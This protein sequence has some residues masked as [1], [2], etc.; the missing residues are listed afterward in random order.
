MEKQT[1]MKHQVVDKFLKSKSAYTKFYLSRRHLYARL[2]VL[3]NNINEIWCM[4]VVCMEKIALPNDGTKFLL[5]CV[6]V[7][8]RFI[9]V[10]TMK[11]NSAQQAKEALARMIL[12]S[13]NPPKRVW[14]DQGKEFEGTFKPFRTAMKIEKYHIQ[15]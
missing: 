9:R 8:S 15:R 4:D 3:A 6:D 2:P 11:A 5:V 1:K 10:Q 13:L 12:D 14:T 7:L